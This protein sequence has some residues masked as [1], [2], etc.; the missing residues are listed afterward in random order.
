MNIPAEKE[1]KFW[2]HSYENRYWWHF[3]KT[4][5][6]VELGRPTF[7]LCFGLNSDR[8]QT[9][10]GHVLGFYWSIEDWRLAKMLPRCANSFSFYWHEWGLWFSPW[11]N[12]W[13]SSWDDPWWRKM[14]HFNFP[15]FFLGKAAYS[16]MEGESFDNVT[17]PM[18]EGNFKAKMTFETCTWKRPLWSAKVRKYT[19]IE[20]EKAPS[21]PGKG[22]NSWDCGDDGIYGMSTEGHSLPKAIGG[23]VQAVMEYRE[24]RKGLASLQSQE[25][26]L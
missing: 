20:L 17:I 4:V 3:G 6:H 11:H 13:E 24:R 2:F 9:I 18:P 23:Y 16:K 25:T 26:K 12:D 21:F 7:S 19:H 15:D 10:H 1:R 14:Y 8:E 22:E 5:F